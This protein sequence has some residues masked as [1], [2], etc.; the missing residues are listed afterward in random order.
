MRD[1]QKIINA[2]RLLQGGKSYSAVTRETGITYKTLR[3][4][5]A[6]HEHRGA[7]ADLQPGNKYYQRAEKARAV[8]DVMENGRSVREVAEELG[9][10]EHSIRGWCERYKEGGLEA[11]RDKRRGRKN[12]PKQ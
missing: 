3:R 2:V 12:A 5:L 11:L 8:I 1:R 9:A 7:E 6:I 4:H 10:T